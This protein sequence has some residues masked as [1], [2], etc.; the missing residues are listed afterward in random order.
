MPGHPGRSSMPVRRR[1]GNVGVIT[2]SH[3]LQVKQKSSQM[4]PKHTAQLP[5]CQDYSTKL[6]L[7]MHAEFKFLK[8]SDK[9]KT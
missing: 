9:R 6:K 5:S 4:C 1:E 7:D 2:N 8:F 3:F